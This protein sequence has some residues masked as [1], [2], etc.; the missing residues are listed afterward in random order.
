MR[1][2]P[3][4]LIAAVLLVPLSLAAQDQNPYSLLLRSGSLTPSPNIT[5]DHINDFNRKSS[6]T[7]GKT[8]AVLQFEQL[9]TEQQKRELKQQGIELLEYIPHNA[10]TVTITGSPG[11]ALLAQYKVRALVELSAQQKMDPGLAAGQFPPR[12]IRVA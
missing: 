1:F 10:Y 3:I 5:P 6:R 9:P 4:P 7:D 12:A 11:A 2:N 8:F